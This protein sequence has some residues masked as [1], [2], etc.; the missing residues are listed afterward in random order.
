ML[1]TQKKNT[2]EQKVNKYNKTLTECLQECAQLKTKKLKTSTKQPL[3]DDNIKCKIQIRRVK[4]YQWNK[5]PT[6][7]NYMAFYYQRRYVTNVI[8]T[9]QNTHYSKL[10]EENKNDFKQIFNIPN[11][12][13]FRNK[14]LPSHLQMTQREKCV[15]LDSFLWKNRSNNEHPTHEPTK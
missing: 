3:F 13:L 1:D 7:Y 11:K 4:G 14:P 6:E 5:A 15:T 9:A 10:L 2:L 8:R 12:L